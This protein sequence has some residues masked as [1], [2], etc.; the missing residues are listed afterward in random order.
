MLSLS[1]KDSGDGDMWV[2]HES[3]SP[4]L[5]F[6][7]LTTLP[8][9]IDAKYSNCLDG[10]AIVE[11]ILGPCPPMPLPRSCHQRDRVVVSLLL[12]SIQLSATV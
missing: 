1:A 10:A 12:A 8:T 7:F 11:R 3:I 5:S 9:E 4:I 2:Y 6:P